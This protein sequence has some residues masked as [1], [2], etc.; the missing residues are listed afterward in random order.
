MTSWSEG[1]LEERVLLNPAFCA[2]ILWHFASAGNEEGCRPLTFV[3]SFL[4]LP[5]VLHRSTR[6]S[7]PRST[8]TSLSVWMD[9]NPSSRAN[10]ATRAKALAPYT[11]NALVFGGSRKFIHIKSGVIAADGLWKRQVNASLREATEEVRTCA[12][13][14]KFVGAWFSDSGTATTV[15]ALMGVRP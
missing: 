11:R 14:A 12:K 8:R 4:V 5:M 7:L 9:E 15:M 3:E 6:D 13:R 1:T 2:H 10:V